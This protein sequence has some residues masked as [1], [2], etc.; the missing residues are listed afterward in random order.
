MV[1]AVAAGKATVK[2]PAKDGSGVFAVATIN[3][4]LPSGI[5]VPVSSITVTGKANVGV[6][7]TMRL[8]AKVLPDTATVKDVKWVSS[9]ETIAKVDANGVVTGIKAGKAVIKAIATDGTGVYGEITITVTDGANANGGNRT[10]DNASVALYLVM[11]LLGIS[12]LVTLVL[13]R[14]SVIK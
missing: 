9:D 1:T 4:K 14:R 2:V 10:G 7:K 5:R 12:G 13:K 8:T 6:S 11:I 3:V